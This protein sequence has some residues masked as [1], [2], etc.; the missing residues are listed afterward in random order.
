MREPI[1]T[2]ARTRCGGEFLTTSPRGDLLSLAVLDSSP[3]LLLSTLPPPPSRRSIRLRLSSPILV[4]IFVFCWIWFA[5]AWL[6]HLFVFW[7]GERFFK[8]SGGCDADRHWT[9]AGGDPGRA[10]GLIFFDF[11]KFDWLIDLDIDISWFCSF[12]VINRGERGLIWM[13]QLVPSEPR[14]VI[15]FGL[16]LKEK[17]KVFSSSDSKFRSFS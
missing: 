7:S 12:F 5:I 6:T 8:E 2:Q 10:R 17:S 11:G 9:R 3:R 15:F 14:L 4:Y 1:Q 13:L 16:I